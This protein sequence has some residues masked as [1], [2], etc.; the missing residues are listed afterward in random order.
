MEKENITHKIIG[1]AYNVFNTLGFG[2][3]E[4]IYHKAL[5]IELQ[6]AGLKAESEKA[7]KVYYNDIVIG[8]FSIDV[9]V[10]DAVVIELK[11]VENLSKVHEVQLVNYL[12]GIKKDI[13][14]LINFGPSRVEVKRKYRKS[15]TECAE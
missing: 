2:F 4:S 1:A 8:D 13:G 3:L 9:F 5:L 6:K 7:L 11:S 15:K 12:N 10:E 14:L